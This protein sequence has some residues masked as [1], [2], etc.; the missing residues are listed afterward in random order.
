MYAVKRSHNI[1]RVSPE[2]AKRILAEHRP[3]GLFYTEESGFYI[4]IDNRTGAAWTEMFAS[5]YSCREWLGEG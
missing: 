2:Y 1:Q 5:M 3:L 4:G